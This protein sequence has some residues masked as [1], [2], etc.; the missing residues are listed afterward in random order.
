[1]LMQAAN[2]DAEARTWLKTWLNKRFGTTLKEMK[3]KKK[4]KKKKQ[5]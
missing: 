2:I 3:K 1:M 5:S 4:K